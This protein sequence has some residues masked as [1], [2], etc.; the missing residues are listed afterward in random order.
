MSL[1]IQLLILKD[2]MTG[3]KSAFAFKDIPVYVVLLP[4]LSLLDR[5][6]II[7]YCES[8]RNL[9]ILDLTCFQRKNNP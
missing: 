9:W 6:I 5:Y 7:L 1:F 3:W 4:K 2:K 8:I